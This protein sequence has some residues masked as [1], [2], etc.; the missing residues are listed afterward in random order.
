M[1]ISI[2]STFTTQVLSADDLLPL[3]RML[4]LFGRAFDDTATYS[5]QQPDDSYLQQLIASPT[6]VA[7]AALAGDDV[8]GGLAG[9]VLPKFEQQ[10]SEFYIYDLAVAES[11]RR[12]GIATAMIGELQRLAAARGIYVIFVQADH[13]DDPAI[14]LYTKLG[15]R[16]DVL[17]F[18][19][20]PAPKA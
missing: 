7:I 10:R 13:G 1:S 15:V 2:S 9:Y 14:A 11:H 3:R 8:V 4:E 12:Q 19:I 16:E 5:A 18:D 6:F 17:H 20:A